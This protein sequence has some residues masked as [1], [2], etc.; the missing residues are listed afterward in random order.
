LHKPN[1]EVVL[2][3]TIEHRAFRRTRRN[4]KTRYRAPRFLNRKRPEGWLPP[5]IQSIVDNIKNFIIKL[6][7]L[8]YIETIYIET[9][10][11]DTQLMLNPSTNIL[12]HLKFI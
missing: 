4:R 8:C 7:K 11:F 3:A 9:V 10:R 2:L 1:G 6:K 12:F 5:S